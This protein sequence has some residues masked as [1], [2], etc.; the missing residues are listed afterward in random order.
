MGLYLCV[1]DGDE[2]LDGIDLGSYDDYAWLI[3]T[4]VEKMEDGA[5][6]LRYLNLVLQSDADGF[7]DPKACGDLA[8]ELAEIA[9]R[10]R[11]LPPIPFRARWQAAV[12]S[13]VG[14]KCESLFDCFIDVDGEPVLERMRALAW[15][16]FERGLPLLR[17]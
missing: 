1:F 12:A 16:A 8:A 6:G 7:W 14:L 10:F 4:V 2:E 11:D 9:G 5:S 15:L 17:Q 13:E 3:D